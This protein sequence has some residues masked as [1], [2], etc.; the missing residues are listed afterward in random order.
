MMR[1][2]FHSIAKAFANL[3]DRHGVAANTD[4]THTPDGFYL[5]RDGNV[6]S[7][8]GSLKMKNPSP[9]VPGTLGELFASVGGW[10]AGGELGYPS[11]GSMDALRIY[12]QRAIRGALAASA[13]M[14]QAARDV[15][16]ERR[17]Q[18]ELFGWDADHDDAHP[19][20][21][22]AAYAAFYAIPR[23]ARPSFQPTGQFQRLVTVDA[24]W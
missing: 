4:E 13:V 1:R 21:E 7:D 19:N 9:E 20:G 18:V 14:P 16:A 23:S 17:R 2:F 10:M 22:I 12:T 6:Y 8:D 3:I 5:G 15:L 24:S 11:F